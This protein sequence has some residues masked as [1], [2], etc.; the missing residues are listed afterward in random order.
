MSDGSQNEQ[1]KDNFKFDCTVGPESYEH[2]KVMNRSSNGLESQ[3]YAAHPQF[4]S[5][6][7]LLWSGNI[8]ELCNSQGVHNCEFLL[9]TYVASLYFQFPTLTPSFSSLSTSPTMFHLLSVSLSITSFSHLFSTL[10]I[11][12]LVNSRASHVPVGHD[13]VQHLELARDIAGS[14]NSTYGD[15]F[16]MPSILLGMCWIAWIIM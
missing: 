4:T 16:T 10:Y 2:Q 13:Q 8:Y 1:T 7:A 3:I 12:F 15:T 5:I 9:S 6:V 14:F 11:S